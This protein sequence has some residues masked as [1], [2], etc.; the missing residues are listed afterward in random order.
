[1]IGK[2]IMTAPTHT[3]VQI[4]DTHIVPE[5]ALLHDKVDTTANLT[6]A[7]AGAE[8]LGNVKVVVLTGDLADTADQ[9]AYRRLRA[10]V[11]EFTTRS[12]IPVLYMMGNHDERAAFRTGLLGEEPSIEPYDHSSEHDGLRVIV[13]DSTVPGHHYGECTPEQLDWLRTELA[14]PAPAGTVLAL[15]HPPMPMAVPLMEELGFRGIDELAG[16]IRGTDVRIVLSGHAHHAAATVLAGIPVWISGATAYTQDGFAGPEMLRGV[17]GAACTRVDVYPG[18][19][20][21]TSVPVT[22]PG[23]VYEA[24]VSELLAMAGQ[25]R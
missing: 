9:A 14:T 6:A 5:G 20:T 4:S 2:D 8:A 25:A 7:L 17:V 16:V 15:H 12:G 22:P 23:T 21:A 3:I 11:D 10:I 13:M 18:L 1:M 24:R 19:A